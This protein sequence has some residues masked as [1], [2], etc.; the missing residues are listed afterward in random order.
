MVSKAFTAIILTFN[1]VL[2]FLIFLSGAQTITSLS[3]NSDPASQ[4]I[5]SW[6][7]FWKVM[8]VPY[9]YLYPSGTPIPESLTARVYFPTYG[10][11]I[12]LIVNILFGLML[13][14]KTKEK[15]TN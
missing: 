15:S 8:I 10:F 14:R 3:S 9:N 2:A 4:P 12:L 7:N 6:F 5:V 1:T 11:I 13:L